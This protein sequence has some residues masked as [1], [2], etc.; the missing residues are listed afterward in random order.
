MVISTTKMK[1]DPKVDGEIMVLSWL[2][3]TQSQGGPEEAQSYGGLE[4]I[5]S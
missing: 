1:H 2:K 5:W 3:K 4:E